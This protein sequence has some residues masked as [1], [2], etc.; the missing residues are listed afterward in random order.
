[1]SEEK[2]HESGADAPSEAPAKAETAPKAGHAVEHAPAG[3][4]PDWTKHFEELFRHVADMPE[5]LVNALREAVPAKEQ[6]D[7]ENQSNVVHQEKTEV[8]PAKKGEQAV[9]AGLAAGKKAPW[10]HRWLGK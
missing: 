1:M 6:D 3:P 8:T 7:D 10:G 5:K 2:T 4:A 9:G